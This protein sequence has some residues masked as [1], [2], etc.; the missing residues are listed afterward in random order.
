[1]MFN[2]ARFGMMKDKAIFI[3]TSRGEIVDEKALVKAIKEKNIYAAS[4]FSK[5]VSV[6]IS[7]PGII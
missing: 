7:I 5:S 3:N 1:M 6:T 2:D 4:F